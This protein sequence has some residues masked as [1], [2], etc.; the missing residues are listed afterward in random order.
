MYKAHL[1]AVL[2]LRHW[3]LLVL[4]ATALISPL[5]QADTV[6]T[7]TGNPFENFGPSNSGTIPT[8]PPICSISGSMVLTSP[9]DFTDFQLIQV[10]S[11]SFTDQ[12]SVLTSSNADGF[13]SVAG[14]GFGNI[15]QWALDIGEGTGPVQL[16]T[17]NF[18]GGSTDSSGAP[19]Q[20]FVFVAGNPGVWTSSTVETPEPSVLALQILGLIFA[21]L[22]SLRAGS[23]SARSI[24]A[25]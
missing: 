11:F 17:I 4:V 3:A 21:C 25:P 6:Y 19:S 24:L 14:D 8:C 15:S 5:A 9:I 2:K 12:D 7:Y 18:E 16:E 23:A 22:F 20:G 13:I 10:L 1:F